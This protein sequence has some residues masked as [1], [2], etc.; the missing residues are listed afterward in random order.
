MAHSLR[1]NVKQLI[2]KKISLE[3]KEIIDLEKGIFNWCIQ[4]ADL[5]GMIKSWSNPSFKILYEDRARSVISNLDPNS[6]I[7]NPRLLTRLKEGEFVPHEVPFMK[8]DH[9]YPELWRETNDLKLKR[10]QEVGEN[11]L[12]SNTDLFKCGRCHKREVYYYEKQTRS[13]DE[14]QT[15][16][17]VCI[18]C[19][20]RWRA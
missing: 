15:C 12:V 19:G 14:P 8:P 20:N 10:D 1:D 4:Y 5:H 13:A 11:T 6:Y 2:T 7:N 16:F 18:Q 17:C 9:L 3:E